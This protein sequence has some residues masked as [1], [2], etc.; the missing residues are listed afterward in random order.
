MQ[1]GFIRE[2]TGDCKADRSKSTERKEML[3]VLHLDVQDK[4]FQGTASSGHDKGK[5]D[6]FYR[7]LE[8]EK[9]YQPSV[10]QVLSGREEQ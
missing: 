4:G 7:I 2:D 6:A 9:K 5:N 3:S 10:F 8:S 1:T